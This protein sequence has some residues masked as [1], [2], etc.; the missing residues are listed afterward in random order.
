MS[1]NNN[2]DTD[3]GI[4]LRDPKHRKLILREIAALSF[5]ELICKLMQ[6]YGINR[7]KY[8]KKLGIT[9]EKLDDILDGDAAANVT[10]KKA[11]EM[12][13]IFDHTLEC[14]SNKLD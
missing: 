2:K 13:S 5:T 14:S 4:A 9:R 6:S 1:M 12:L 3:F 8:A 7:K 10:L 11:S